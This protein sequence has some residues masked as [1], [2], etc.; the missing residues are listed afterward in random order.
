V[1]I[2]ILFAEGLEAD[3]LSYAR[4]GLYAQ[5]CCAGGLYLPAS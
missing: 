2:S 1:T 4:L 5:S 3:G